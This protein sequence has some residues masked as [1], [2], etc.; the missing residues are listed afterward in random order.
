MGGHFRDCP[1][2]RMEGYTTEIRS[3]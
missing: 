3:W 2:I 1:I